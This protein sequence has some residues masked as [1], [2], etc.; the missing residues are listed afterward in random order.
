MYRHICGGGERTTK[1][2]IVYPDGSTRTIIAAAYGLCHIDGRDFIE[3]IDD[4]GKVTEVVYKQLV[5]DFICIE[6]VDEDA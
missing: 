3:F 5:K 4:E 6:E 1:C 2:I